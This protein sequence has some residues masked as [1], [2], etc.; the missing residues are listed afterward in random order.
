MGYGTYLVTSSAV[1]WVDVKVSELTS[2]D[3][4]G[5]LGVPQVGQEEVKRWFRLA[6]Q[7]ARDHKYVGAFPTFY[8]PDNENGVT[9]LMLLKA[10]AA[11][12]ITVRLADLGSERT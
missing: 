7:Y 9:G 8:T 3:G 11:T 5:P 12:R 1:D 6:D 10:E 2:L 4:G